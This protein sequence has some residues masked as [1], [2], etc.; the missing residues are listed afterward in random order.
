[1]PGIDKIYIPKPKTLG[2]H[3]YKYVQELNGGH[4]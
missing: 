2:R 1:M 4:G 3:M